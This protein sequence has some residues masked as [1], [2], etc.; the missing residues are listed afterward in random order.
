MRVPDDD[1]PI[2]HMIESAGKIVRFV[3]GRERIDLDEDEQLNLSLVRL[4]EIVG[5]AATRV[6]QATRDANPSIPWA[7]IIGMRNR[8]IHGYD[9]VDTGILWQTVTSDIPPLLDSL[10]QLENVRNT[11]YE[12]DDD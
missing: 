12:S 10:A 2:R 7:Q 5:E 9:V 4:L 1:T 8:L 3:E 11:R 6:S